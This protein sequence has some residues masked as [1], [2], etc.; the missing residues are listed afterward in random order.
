MKYFQIIIFALMV[1][2]CK[3]EITLTESNK[4]PIKYLSH[5]GSVW[6][7]AVSKDPLGNYYLAGYAINP[8]QVNLKNG[9]ILKVNPQLNQE[10][11]IETNGIR[12]DIFNSVYFQ[13]NL[14][15]AGGLSY[16]QIKTP[17]NNPDFLPDAL[18]TMVNIEGNKAFDKYLV[19][20]TTTKGFNED[21]INSIT[22]D[23]TDIF[24]WGFSSNF[25]E[26]SGFYFGDSWLLRS[27]ENGDI[28]REANFTS[29]LLR[30]DKGLKI[31]HHEKGLY[32]LSEAK[33]ENGFILYRFDPKTQDTMIAINSHF[34]VLGSSTENALNMFGNLN[35]PTIVSNHY[36][37]DKNTITFYQFNEHLELQNEFTFTLNGTQSLVKGVK[38]ID[39]RLYVFGSER[40]QS[41]LG[42]LKNAWIM[43]LN[44]NYELLWNTILPADGNGEIIDCFNHNDKLIVFGNLQGANQPTKSFTC[45]LNT[46]G[47]INHE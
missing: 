35:G 25:K 20:N 46:E 44:T 45:L 30:K 21:E 24:L 40:K 9:L 38:L 37:G 8:N 14:I 2:G 16:S 28:E 42:S 17:G 29:P 5:P 7:N 27:N 4:G 47:E 22:G 6:I 1:L 34:Q 18:F 10:W 32:A 36:Q 11:Q 19:P 39:N 43:C 41:T 13:N 23:G 33:E 12:D 31:I 3:K 26:P 15:Y